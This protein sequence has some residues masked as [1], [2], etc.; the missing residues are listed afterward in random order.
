M[1]R[2]S[3]VRRKRI[4]LASAAALIVSVVQGVALLGV[5][6]AS[7]S[8]LITN[9]D[10]E[11][12]LTTG[13]TQS[14]TPTGV[15]ATS[16]LNPG[17]NGGFASI[18]AQG[19]CWSAFNT[20]GLV[21]PGTH[22][23]RIRAAAPTT[24]TTWT[25]ILTS[26]QFTA[27]NS[28]TF[29]AES[30]TSGTTHPVPSTLTVNIL[31]PTNSDAV[32]STQV[33]SPNVVQLPGPTG[34]TSA[35]PPAGGFSSHTIDTSSWAGTPIKVQFTQHS[36]YAGLGY[37]TLVDNVA[38][39]NAAGLSITQAENSGPVLV[40]HDTTY[41]FT[42]HNAG[43]D[44]ANSL[45]VTDVL[46]AGT[47]YAATQP[48]DTGWTCNEL[49]VGTVT[50]SLASPLGS[51]NDVALGIAVT[52]AGPSGAISNAA[53]ASSPD[54]PASPVASNTVT[55]IVGAADLSITKSGDPGP[56][57]IGQDLT[58]GFTVTNA[59][60]DEA[61]NVILTD[62]LPANTSFATSQPPSD[63]GWAC[64]ETE[65]GSGVVDCSFTGSM[66][67]GTSAV[68]IAATLNGP[69]GQVSNTATV[70]SPNDTA[71]GN[72]TSN[73]IATIVGVADLSISAFSGSPDPVQTSHNIT[74]DV[75]VHNDGP[76][77]ATDVT[78]TDTLPSGTTFVPAGSGT[79]GWS[80]AA[81]TDTVVCSPTGNGPLPTGDSTFPIVLQAPNTV[82]H[83]PN[84][85][86]AG[87]PND[88]NLEN[89]SATTS[90]VV[91]TANL[92]LTMT[93]NPDLH[94]ATGALY[95]YTLDV[96]NSGPDPAVDVVV[97]DDLSL[98]GVTN[99]T[100]S[101]TGWTCAAT[102]GVV[103]CTPTGN[104]PLATGHSTITIST[105]AP[106]A[107]GTISNTATV[108][109]P[110]EIA[111]GDESGSQS[112]EVG[113]ADLRTSQ[114]QSASVG[115]ILAPVTSTSDVYAGR[116]ITYVVTVHNDGPDLATVPHVTD[117]LPS[118][119]TFSSS[120][121]TGWSCSG[122]T[123]VTCDGPNISSHGSADVT[124]V[125]S[126]SSALRHG[127][128]ARTNTATVSSSI[129]DNHPGN[130]QSTLGVMVD[131]VPEP[132]TI[133]Q[134][135]PDSGGAG[136]AWNASTLITAT[137]GTGL[138]GFKIKRC[139]A[140]S[141]MP[142][143]C[144][145]S[146]SDAATTPSPISASAFSALVTGLSNGTYYGFNVVA[147][148]D[149]GE[150][151]QSPAYPSTGGSTLPTA[152]ADS[153]RLSASG[154]GTADNGFSGGALT[155][156]PNDPNYFV[157]CKDIV[158]KYTFSNTSDAFKLI[159][160]SVVPSAG[161]ACAKVDL[162]PADGAAF[163]T[164]IPGECPIPKTI[165]SDYPL[166]A[167]KKLH[168]E[169]DQLDGAETT[170]KEGAPCT[171][172]KL[173]TGGTPV[174]PLMCNDANFT[175][176][177]YQAIGGGLTNFCELAVRGNASNQLPLSQTG[178]TAK[179]P[180]AY[181]YFS[182]IR[183]PGFDLGTAP[184]AATPNSPTAKRNYTGT[185]AGG[186]PIPCTALGCDPIVVIGSSIAAGITL[187][188]TIGGKTQ[189]VRPWCDKSLSYAPCVFK[190]MWLNSGTA[191]GNNDIQI[192]TY[193]P[194]DASRTITG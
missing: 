131:T 48:A 190:W 174:F 67:A 95:T 116:N 47:S 46:P 143:D 9:G 153:Q 3:S 82:G 107:E 72:N 127:A 14:G 20:S 182:A 146:Q 94:V 6:P 25:G 136:V 31:D 2:R 111:P 64:A 176:Y 42:V 177:S 173:M 78:V 189:V 167:A 141:V 73:S 170:A 119:F 7:A 106:S 28:V 68:N 26:D 1:N 57:A 97:T 183:I 149:V 41:N 40:G 32:L 152:S 175:K 63:P 125:A 187:N 50:C 130:N 180:C 87:S 157:S 98:N 69:S 70:S 85:V 117:T 8:T 58:Y 178:W 154:L 184:V 137:G 34:C 129:F 99:I 33:V 151:D 101:G 5:S 81:P 110:S 15:T 38:T 49:P 160:V 51:A 155:C 65:A 109:S 123:S 128:L 86:T 80:C 76:N 90:T 185:V 114:T 19:T 45:T 59:G 75:T 60:P 103:T 4:A 181:I 140:S 142:N 29:D 62:V 52:A 124:I 171:S 35:T 18:V 156:N 147:T 89:N 102:L 24:S 134:V 104:A 36:K 23:A 164:Q 161:A 194:G 108:S 91:G 37:F 179:H 113:I 144:T 126:V 17:G 163:G 148:N 55:T 120:S 150:S 186:Y 139:V 11:Q 172:L 56:V 44:P 79:E 39:V 27:G 74:Y 193:M 88:N 121:G 53:M 71:T 93:D 54:D 84:T 22:S 12:S 77:A 112:V 66:T 188:L 132:P 168:L 100:P 145:S 165:T 191:S 43:P 13:W 96:N 166:T 118:D 61:T 159:S 16:A 122:T 83:L 10:F 162:N 192:Q 21:L 133:T 158:N 169:Y 138:T 92:S 30:E 115:P 135:T 105:N